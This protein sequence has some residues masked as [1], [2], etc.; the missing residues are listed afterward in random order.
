MTAITA[1]LPIKGDPRALHRVFADDPGV[2]LPGSRHRG[3]D[4]WLTVVRGAG[5]SRIVLARVSQAWRASSTS[6][7][8]VS[9]QPLVDEREPERIAWYMPTLVGELGLH[10]E[11]E[12]RTSLV[13][14]ARYQPPGGPLGA[15]LN[16]LALHRIARSTV[17]RFLADIAAAISAVVGVDPTGAGSPDAP[18]SERT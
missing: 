8:T 16:A 14:D 6:W 13:L 10:A 15:S 9:W 3:D 1:F 12:G 18:R 17:D 7:R 2:W 4:R 5:I 11:A